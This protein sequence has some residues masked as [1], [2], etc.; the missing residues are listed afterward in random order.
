MRRP[1]ALDPIRE[2][3]HTKDLDASTSLE[4]PLSPAKSPSHRTARHVDII[5]SQITLSQSPSKSLIER[6]PKAP[7]VEAI[8]RQFRP[9]DVLQNGNE[10]LI[11]L[12]LVSESVVPYVSGYP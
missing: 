6:I 3:I 10:L 1:N 8:V 5:K 7:E 12:R 4:H 9:Q 2:S 11:S